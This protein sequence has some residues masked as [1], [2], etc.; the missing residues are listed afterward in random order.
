MRALILTASITV[1]LLAGCSKPADY[2]NFSDEKASADAAAPAAQTAP[3]PNA[4]VITP[5]SVATVATPMLAYSY[6]YGIETPPR[7][8]AALMAKHQAACTA[9]GPTI[10][11]VTGSTLDNHGEDAIRGSLALRAT[12]VWLGR[13][14][15]SLAEDAR[16]AG[17]RVVSASVTSEDLSRQVIDVQAMIRAKTALRD[18]L[19]SILESRPAKT[20]D[21]VEVETAL[22]KTQGELDASQSEMAA[23][24]ARLD[25]SVLTIEYNAD[26]DSVH[27]QTWAPLKDAVHG[28]GAT[29]VR[30]VA[31]MITC[32]ASLLPWVT[33]LGGGTWLFRGALTKASWPWGRRRAADPRSPRA[34]NTE[35]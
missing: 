4:P 18:R 8:V 32:V 13:F 29:L 9:A 21:L 7:R 27:W 35:M 23:M 1:L 10:C 2:Q 5:G 12:P 26:A 6:E 33:V 19:Q 34:S 20:A 15:A 11:Q 14:R 22:S 17:G 24:R 16:K 25:S 28:F 30:A 31:F 3:P